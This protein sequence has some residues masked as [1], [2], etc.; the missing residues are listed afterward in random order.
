MSK[1]QSVIIAFLRANERMT[2]DQ[3]VGLIG[4]NYYAHAR[5]WTG[6]LLANMVDRGMIR[7]WKPGVF[8]GAAH[9][10]ANAEADFRLNE[11]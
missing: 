7:R 2:L 4:Q 1:K 11:N 3:A 5:V 9:S 10:M 8:I 6:K